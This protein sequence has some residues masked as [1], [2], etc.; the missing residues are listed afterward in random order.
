MV[1]AMA[2]PTPPARAAI[3]PAAAPLIERH[4]EWLGGWAAFDGLRDM[5][6]EGTISVAGLNGS[7]A[8]QLRADGR[9]RTAYDL[10]V[11]SG[12]EA[13]DGDDAWERN[14]SGQVED[15]GRD[16]AADQ[17][18]SLDRAFG[19]HF[20][21][22]GV[23]VSV[24]PD[25][26][27]DGRTWSVLRF[28]YPDGDLYDLLV[29]AATGESVWT[30]QT[31]DGREQWSRT[32]EMRE[33]GG[34]R[35]A[36]RQETLHEQALHNQTVTWSTVTVNTGLTDD[37][38]LRPGAA[39]ATRLY[40]LPEG[41][42][43]TAWMPMELYMERYIYLQGRVD[44]VAT[45]ILLDSGAGITVLDKAMADRLGRKATGALP[46]RG[47]G[48]T[49]TAGLLEGVT[50]EVG[51]L[52]LGPIVAASL[53]L[54]DIEWRLGRAMPVIL[55]KEVFHSLVVDID[56][57]NGRIR[58]VEPD[59]FR[60]E[61]PGRRLEVL[62]GDDGHKLLHLSVEGLPEALVSLDTGQGGA[63]TLFRPYAEANGLLENRRTSRALGGGVGGTMELTSLRLKTVTIAG[64]E[65]R[66]VPTT[67]PL[68]DV[69]GAFNTA[70]LAGNLGT[71]IL[72]R[73]RVIFDYKRDCLWMEPG[74]GFD[75]PHLWDRT[76]LTVF[77]DDTALVVEHVAPG[78]PAE[79]AGWKPGE[80]V[81]A[82]DGTP[83]DKDWWRIWADWSRA[84]PG[85][86]AELTMADGTVRT[87]ALADYF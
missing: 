49:T 1:L 67:V 8:V 71:G 15:M 4:V 22:V 57:P 53:D 81:T 75:A 55:G 28:T 30:R 78:S 3:A 84:T 54:S 20:R 68:E 6:L 47:V 43:A 14:A 9:Q 35:L 80:R 31:T 40:R 36:F 58:F 52:T 5:S 85:T 51:E 29:D 62:P 77:R 50:L 64:F 39:A 27:K 61:G 17:V 23:D 65:L 2:L 86:M 82:L 60:Y 73:F 66:D 83:V 7:L 11:M 32:S 63:L 79:A 76:G 18:R 41:A 74:A 69:G 21:G 34:R 87:L 10:K 13:V 12:T 38:F 37:L 72:N 19:R 45:D 16:K 70:K 59:A 42:T 24:L 56:Y 46:A 33:V 26:S 44:G 25:E 48:G